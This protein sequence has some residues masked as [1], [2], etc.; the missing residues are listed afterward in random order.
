MQRG[1]IT[2]TTILKILVSVLPNS[3]IAFVSRAYE[4]RMTDKDVTLRS[5]FL[6]TL[7]PYC[8]I[9]A[10]KGFNIF[11]DCADFRV[12]LAK[13]PGRRGLSQLPSGAVQ[14]TKKVANKR[15]LVEQVIE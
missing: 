3:M 15:I 9:M 6:E 7:P 13:P 1:V 4:G 2:N 5:Q 8:S 14:E 11:D 12:T 10:D